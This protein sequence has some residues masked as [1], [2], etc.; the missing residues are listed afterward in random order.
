M[1]TKAQRLVNLLRTVT[2]SGKRIQPTSA[3]IVAAGSSSRMGEVDGVKKQHI[4]LC[5]IPV[6]VRSMQAFEACSMIKE[7]IVVAREDEISL[8]DKYKEKYNITKLKH[9]VAGGN[10]RQESVLNGVE[11]ISPDAKFI[12]IHD[13]ARCLVTVKMIED[14][15]LAAYRYRAATAATAVRDTVK[16]CDKH[17]FIDTTIDRDTVWLAQTPQAFYANLYRAAAYVARDEGF[18][19]TDDNMLAEHIRIC[20]RSGCGEKK[21]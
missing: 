10:T 19:A 20:R 13:G 17:G 2:G 12:A 5:G 8:Y 4:E 18:V 6:V 9:V 3:V 16:V 15:C 21:D 7:I 11:A 1:I 14:V